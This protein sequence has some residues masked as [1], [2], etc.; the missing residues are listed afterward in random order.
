MFRIE[1]SGA[2]FAW[3][4]YT[5]NP[6]DS[7]IPYWSC[8]GRAEIFTVTSLILL[9]KPIDRESMY[10]GPAIGGEAFFDRGGVV[11]FAIFCKQWRHQPYDV[12]V[13]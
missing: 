4:E 10:I 13:M 7:P 12:T 6:K 8:V 2:C 9:P 11:N 5:V 1:I 3:E